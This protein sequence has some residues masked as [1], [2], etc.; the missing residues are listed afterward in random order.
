MKMLAKIGTWLARAE[1]ARH[2]QLHRET[3]KQIAALMAE[4]SA[5]KSASL[6]ARDDMARHARASEHWQ[7]EWRLLG[8]TVATLR[9]TNAA[10]D[11][12]LAEYDQKLA[13]L[14]TAFQDKQRE[15]TDARAALGFK[16]DEIA[17]LKDKLG[18]GVEL[19]GRAAKELG[20]YREL[21]KAANQACVLLNDALDEDQ[22]SDEDDEDYADDEDDHAP[23]FDEDDAPPEAEHYEE[24]DGEDFVPLPHVQQL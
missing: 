1:L 18:R 9:Q 11:K 6:D 23:L 5:V 14:A 7:K 22:A 13:K 3:G 17:A 24:D 16:D 15:L 10:R 20:R 21:M 4:L 2:E 8:E 19:G 12:E